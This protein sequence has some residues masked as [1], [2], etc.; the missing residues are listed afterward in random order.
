MPK[1]VDAMMAKY[2]K[3]T[4]QAAESYKAGIDAVTE[5][6][7]EKAANR[8]DK[9]VAG[10]QRAADSGKYE[11][12]LRA[13]TTE[14]W[15]AAAKNKGAAALQNAVRN[16]SARAKRNMRNLFDYSQTVA[17]QI[18]GMADATEAD[19]DARALKAIQLMR[20]YRKS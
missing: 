4:G 9:Y 2:E 15:K 13:V 10:V 14:E 11:A 1:N 5:S 6:P 18:A 20:Q 8:K 12:G 17:S 16:L 7:T 3:N 19:A